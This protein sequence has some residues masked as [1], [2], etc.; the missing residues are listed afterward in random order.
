MTDKIDIGEGFEVSF[1]EW[2]P[3][4]ELNPQY[5]GVESVEKAGYI[6]W[7]DGSSVGSGWFDLPEVRLIPWTGKRN[8]WTVESWEP[9]TLSPSIQC[10]ELDGKTPSYHGWIRE[11][12]WVNA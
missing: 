1:F 6:L 4:R 9:L 2:D 11:G 12:R 3:E 10:H 5:E 8:L 7:R